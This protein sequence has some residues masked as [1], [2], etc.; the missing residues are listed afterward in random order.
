MRH[1]LIL[2]Q[3]QPTRQALELTLRR[4]GWKVTL[5]TTDRELL[6]ALEHKPYDVVL[7]DLDM[8]TGDGWRVLETLSTTHNP[9]PVVAL[10]GQES[11]RRPDALNL[12]VKV[13]LPKPLGRRTLLAGLRKVR[14]GSSESR[15]HP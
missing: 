11:Q 5:T 12:G 14:D 6:V 4:A 3:Y 9:T 1:V 15:E 2:E 13:I 10:L 8:P 7:I